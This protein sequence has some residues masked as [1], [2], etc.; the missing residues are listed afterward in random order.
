MRLLPLLLEEFG[1]FL[2]QNKVR[3]SPLA[4]KYVISGPSLRFLQGWVWSFA[5]SAS[6]QLASND[7]MSLGRG[8]GDRNYLYQYSQGLAKHS[9]EHKE[10]T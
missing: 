3:E 9:T 5:L 2:I 4:D 10:T 8:G 1:S 6:S 7:D